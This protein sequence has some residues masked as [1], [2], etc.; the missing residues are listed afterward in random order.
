MKKIDLREL[1][2]L[3]PISFVIILREDRLRWFRHVEHENDVVLG[4]F[5]PSIQFVCVH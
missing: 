2:G 4:N 3:E 5:H 1:L